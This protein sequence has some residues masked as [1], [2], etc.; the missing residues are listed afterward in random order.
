MFAARVIE[1]IILNLSDQLLLTGLAVLI[2]AFWT[3]CSISVYHFA[4]SGDLAWFASNVHLITLSVLRQYLRERPVLRNW[5]VILMTCMAF[6]LVASTIM[7][8]HQFW[9]DS[10]PYE[11]QCVFN[12]LKPG[13]FGGDPAVWMSVDLILI[14]IGYPLNIIA[15]YDRPA[16]FVTNLLYTSPR[17]A[18]AGA[19]GYLNNNRPMTV[20]ASPI[21]R[22][23]RAFY[24]TLIAYLRMIRAVYTFLYELGSSRW[25]NILFTTGWFVAGLIGLFGDKNIPSSDMDDDENAMTF[26]QIVP[27]LVLSSTIVVAREAYEGE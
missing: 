2:A 16:D 23:K 22:F 12:D 21:N 6:F 1:K 11:A 26:G 24:T 27:V 4:I 10:W 3:H 13:N 15:L 5:R 20:Q 19:I 14:A 25:F 9:Y 7:Q 18:M 17:K 8:G